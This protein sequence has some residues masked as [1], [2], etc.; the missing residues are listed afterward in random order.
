MVRLLSYSILTLRL[1]FIP[2]ITPTILTTTRD[3]VTEAMIQT[4]P[5]IWIS[6]TTTEMDKLQS[7]I[8][9]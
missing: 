4:I 3:S 1:L 5:M 2:T 7:F 8:P 9:G 6:P